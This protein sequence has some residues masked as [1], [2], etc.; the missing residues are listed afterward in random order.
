M[1]K[2]ELRLEIDRNRAASLGVSARDISR[3]LQILLGGQDISEIKLEGKQY[4]LTGTVGEQFETWRR[5]L[6]RI[7]LEESGLGGEGGSPDV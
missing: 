7:Y 5:L 2:P 3:T 4:E 1:N 6:R